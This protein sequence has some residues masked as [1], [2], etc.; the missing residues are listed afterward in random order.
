VA[1]SYSQ[2]GQQG[3]IGNQFYQIA[4]TIALAKRNNASYQFPFGLWSTELNLLQSSYSNNIQFKSRYT[5][6]YFHYSPIPFSDG[7]DLYNSY[8]QSEKYFFDFS[9]EIR[10]LLTPKCA[11]YFPKFENTCAIHVRRGDYLT[12]P[13]H[14]PVLPMS[15][16]QEAMN[17][18]KAKKY[19]VFSDDPEWCANNFKGDQFTIMRG[20][21]TYVDIS[22]MSKCDVG[23]IIANS[24][25]SYWGNWLNPNTNKIVIAPKNENWFGKDLK[26]H[27]LK[28]LIPESWIKI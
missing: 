28:D 24:S 15:Y 27:N 4:A 14:H 16:Y 2:L 18:V 7:L 9:D 23:G 21:R 10:Y 3:R 12:L 5:E 8:F 13:D 19:M 25:Y 11:K 26:H 6:P 1:I 22:L 20:N 17:A